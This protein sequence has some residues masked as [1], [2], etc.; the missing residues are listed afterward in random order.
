M[1]TSKRLIKITEFIG[2]NDFVADIGADHGKLIIEIANKYK[3]NRYLAVEN[4]IGPF[5]N[6]KNA[7][8]SYNYHKNIECSLSNGIEYL[9]EYINT[10]VFSG[11]GGYNVINI[12]RKSLNNLK[13]VKKIIFSVHK[14]TLNLEYFLKSYGY[15]PVN[16]ALVED[17]E[18]FYDIVAT[19]FNEE[20]ALI[21]LDENGNVIEDNSIEE[22]LKL[23]ENEC[24]KKISAE[25]WQKS[26]KKQYNKTVGTFLTEGYI[27][28]N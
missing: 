4:K 19:E 25:K 5:T 14:N 20:L 22:K 24:N 17:H 10:L 2:E 6:L 27:D 1:L 15:F 26:G 7:V 18:K 13:N 23:L 8:E 3:N 11:M 12:I 9:P 16:A 21:K 28:E